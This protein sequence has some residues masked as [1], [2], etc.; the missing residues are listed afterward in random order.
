[1]K[2]GLGACTATLKELE[3][4]LGSTDFYLISKLEAARSILT[5]H[6]YMPHIYCGME[7]HSL[8]VETT[9]VQ[10]NCLFQHYG[11]TTVLGTTLTAAIEYLQVEIGV[12]GCPLS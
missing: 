10:I 5:A 7:L 6:R 12:R 11:T 8:P 2:Y 9:V 4:G 3:G 1:M